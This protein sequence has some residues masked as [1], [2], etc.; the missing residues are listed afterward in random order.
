MTTPYLLFIFRNRNLSRFFFLICK[1]K[2]VP[3]GHLKSI[4]RYYFSPEKQFLTFEGI[5]LKNLMK[6]KEHLLQKHENMHKKY[7]CGPKINASV[8][9]VFMTEIN[10]TI[11]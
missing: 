1:H 5:Q 9:A 11:N 4:L 7:A 2:N 8:K 6:T 10:N 3:K